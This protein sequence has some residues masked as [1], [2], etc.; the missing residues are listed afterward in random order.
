MLRGK[1]K[2]EIEWLFLKT[3]SKTDVKTITTELKSQ[4]NRYNKKEVKWKE[5]GGI[6]SSRT[7]N[8]IF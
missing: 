3:C 6:P 1:G 2:V 8:L 4:R 5:P 7:K